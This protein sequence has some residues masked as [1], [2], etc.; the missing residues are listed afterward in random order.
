MSKLL[1]DIDPGLART[2]IR[3]VR[4]G[5]R[6]VTL[7]RRPDGTIYVRSPHP[8]AAY[9]AKLTE[10]LEYWAKKAPNRALIAGRDESGAWRT[11]TYAEALRLVHGIGTALLERDL[12]PERP[13]LILSGNDVDHALLGFAAQYIG[14]P[15]A[16]ISPAYSLISN[17]FG[18][19]R[20]I[21]ELL[22]PGLVFAS[23][24]N[25]FGRAIDA[26]VPPD[27]EVTVVR[28]PLPNRPTT[29]FSELLATK[30]TAVVDVANGRIRPDTI[31][32]FLFTSGS[33]GSPK[34]VINT[35][36]MLCS[37]QAM[38]LS[39]FAYFADEP[40]VLLDWSPWNHTAGGNHNVGLALYNGG[41]FYID[42]GKPMP[43]GIEATVRNL[44]DVA[45]TWYFNVPKGYDA[46]IPHFRT[47][48][49]L[50]EK[51]FSNLKVLFCAGAGLAQHQLEAMHELAVE[52]RGERILFLAGLGSTET[53][54]FAMVLLWHED[55]PSNVG[56]PGQ[57]VELK[58]VPNE[59]KHELRIRSPSVTPGYWR[60]PELT[61]KAFDEEGFYK[62]GD[63]LKFVDPKDASKGFW[64]DGRVTE[65]FKLAT[66]TWVSV[67]PVRARFIDHFAPHVKD[68]VIAGL[69]REAIGVLVFPDVENCRALCPELSAK[70]SVQEV[71]AHP[72]IRAKIK[73]LLRSLAQ[74]ATGSS[75]RI[76]RAIL[77]SEPPSIDTGEMTDKGSIN[78]RAV[79]KNR[80][81]LV[82]ELYASPP[83]PAVIA[84]DEKN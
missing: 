27:V 64:F 26:V 3:P 77:M 73:L 57:G 63:A 58:L 46:L 50:R 25:A 44:R 71:L 82:A 68:V 45:P 33:T 67:G 32:K 18:K 31:A 83:P 48:R 74:G 29:P 40:P 8:L 80:A 41:S 70:A 75:N 21:F 43:G 39:S 53:G 79:L 5:P 76:V 24:G 55:K 13:I 12:S 47:D 7:D 28:N 30:P 16:P 81:A 56:V 66:G 23:D 4:L 72:A 60:A 78:Q 17:D 1:R 19:L 52:T 36:R 10:R 22:T 20:Y 54:P 59:G 69:D 14:V 84:I 65:D 9:P 42:D 35:Q 62:M 6:N 11:V 37:N 51:F 15:Y 49:G 38:I 34:A 61:A 2:P